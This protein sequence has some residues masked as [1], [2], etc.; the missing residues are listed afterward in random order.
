M[1]RAL[2][3]AVLTAVALPQHALAD[4]EIDFYGGGFGHGVGMSQ[5]GAYGLA[6]QGWGRGKIIRWY[7]RGTKLATLGPPKASFRVGLLQRRGSFTLRARRASFTLAV[8]GTGTVDTVAKGD[9]RKIVIS[10]GKYKVFD[11]DTLKGTWGSSSSDLRAIYA[12]TGGLVKVRGWGHR[13]GRGRLEFDIVSSGRAHLV[14]VV[15]PEEYLYGLSE[16][17]SSWPMRVL[18]VQADAGRTYAY[19]VIGGGGRSG[20]SCDIL[21]DTRDQNYVGWDKEAGPSGGRWVRAVRRTEKQVITYGG[22]PASTFYSSSSGGWIESKGAVWGGSVPYL[23]ATC[24][25]GDYTGANPN[26]VWSRT[27]MGR[28]AARKLRSRYGWGIRRVLSISITDR[29]KGG[30]VSE[31]RIRGRRTGGGEGTWKATGENLRVGLGLK[32]AR[33]WVNTNRQVTGSIRRKYDALRCSPGLP[34]SG[35]RRTNGG[36]WQRFKNGR[37]YS[38]GGAGTHYL[39]GAILAKYLGKDGP[40]GRLG[41]PT[42]DVDRLSGGRLRARF[43]GGRIVCRSDGCRARFS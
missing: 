2:A 7:Y 34:S 43:E 10:G 21:G 26:R 24:D 1:K 29:G 41:Y 42:T 8:E 9:S 20:C 22:S 16:V 36:K 30:Y 39:H 3:L 18:E 17:P 14:T 11:G 23:K 38:K 6:Q 5:Y 32:S 27:M 28:E 40:R 4:R 19:R 35:R 25:P 31:A 15:R 33:F 37:I 12:P 13:V